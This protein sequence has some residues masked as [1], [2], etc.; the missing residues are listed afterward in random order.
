MVLAD[1]PHP[2]LLCPIFYSSS[3][4][5]FDWQILG[6]KQAVP[7]RWRWK[8]I[9][10]DLFKRNRSNFT[11]PGNLLLLVP[12]R[13][14]QLSYQSHHD[15]WMQVSFQGNRIRL[16]NVNCTQRIDPSDY[17]RTMHPSC[18][19]TKHEVFCQTSL[20]GSL[21]RSPKYETGSR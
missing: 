13:L 4:Q 16:L 14:L 7:F 11:D 20:F 18:A 12:C 19:C 2:W 17:L 21:I 5:L 9:L 1:S 6:R 3:L 8:R 10:A 15:R